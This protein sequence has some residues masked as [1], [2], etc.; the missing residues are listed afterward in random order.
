MINFESFEEDPLMG[1]LN[2]E[3][4]NE[5]VVL[6]LSVKSSLTTGGVKERKLEKM[7]FPKDGQ[8]LHP[9]WCGLKH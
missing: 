9:D 7:V 8:T 5:E 2:P 1:L 3:E 6:K 4:V